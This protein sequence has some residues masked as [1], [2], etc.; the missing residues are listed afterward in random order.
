MTIEMDPYAHWGAAYVLGSLSAADR[1]EFE[2]HLATCVRCSVE[3]AEVAGMPALLSKVPVDT[4]LELG[5]APA[6]GPATD[7]PA[8][9]SPADEPPADL[10][11]KLI[12]R[13]QPPRRRARYAVLAVAAA[14]VVAAAVGVGV[15]VLPSQ[16]EGP[17][18]NAPHGPSAPVVAQPM[19]PVTESPL[20]A[21]V[22]IVEQDWGT[23]IDVTCRYAAPPGG[24]YGTDKSEYAMVM[25]DKNGDT[26]QLATWT[27][28]AGQTVTPS[29]TTS[30]PM[31]WVD[32][33]DIRSVATNQVL[34]TSTF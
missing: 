23:R 15:A 30:V 3:V 20:T 16:T 9:E 1:D 11:P 2:H 6:A 7:A 27:A 33:V 8:D 13:S 21:D 14:A 4:A 28:V 10:L 22:S 29:A 24:G 19:I 5:S 26:E 25:T 18:P 34:L 31:L 17:S 12:E 32:R